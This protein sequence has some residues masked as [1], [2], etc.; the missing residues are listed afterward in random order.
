[1]NPTMKQ[2]DILAVGLLV[3]VCVYVFYESGT[4]PIP[5]LLGNPLLIPRLVAGC[6]LVAAAALLYRALTGRSLPLARRL[7]GPDLHRVMA[8][9]VFTGGYALLVERV[10]FLATTF[11][12]LLLFGLVLGERRVIRL[13]LFAIVVPVAVH[14]IFDSTLNVPLPQG[15]L[16]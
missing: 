6:L 16:R 3:P 1:M 9:A 2:G 5:A 13:V 11:L 7:Q 4:W 8:A 15:W 12:Y 10:G 14:L